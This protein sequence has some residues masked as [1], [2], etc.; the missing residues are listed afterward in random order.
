MARSRSRPDVYRQLLLD[1]GV[2][3]DELVAIEDEADR[4]VDAATDAARNGP[5]PD[6][7]SAF[8]DV[9]ADGGS[10]GRN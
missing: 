5:E 10:S 8:T 4:D 7:E 1:R 3:E 2:G 6:L 9:W